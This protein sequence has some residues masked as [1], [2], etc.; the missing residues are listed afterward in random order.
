M[1]SRFF[2]DT[3]LYSPPGDMLYVSPRARG[4]ITLQEITDIVAPPVRFKGT[5]RPS[6]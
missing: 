4:S 5:R 3:N 1:E 6:L 2:G